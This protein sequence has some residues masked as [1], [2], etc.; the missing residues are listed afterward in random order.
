MLEKVRKNSRIR[1]F[2]QIS[3]KVNGACPGLRPNLH[4]SF[5]EIYSVV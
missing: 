1:H 3:A 5:M 2:I 4:S